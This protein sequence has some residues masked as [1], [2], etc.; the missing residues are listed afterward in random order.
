MTFLLLDVHQ[1][2]C[3]VIDFWAIQ[4]VFLFDIWSWNNWHVFKSIIQ[5]VL[6]VLFLIVTLLVWHCQWY[7][8]KTEDFFFYWYYWFLTLHIVIQF[9]FQSYL[10]GQETYSGQPPN[11]LH[12]IIRSVSFLLKSV[13]S[14]KA[15]T[16]GSM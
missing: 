13:I 3:D 6:S 12:R 10:L 9:P 14:L 5:F 4:A 2:C 7:L 15:L 11:M 1:M 16:V 8:S